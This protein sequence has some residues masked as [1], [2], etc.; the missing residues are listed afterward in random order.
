MSRIN[1]ELL[2]EKSSDVGEI[3]I[4]IET[5][6]IRV[7][8]D[9]EK[10]DVTV[11]LIAVNSTNGE[12]EF[13]A[14]DTS[15]SVLGESDGISDG[16]KLEIGE[17]IL[18]VCEV[19]GVAAALYP[20]SIPVDVKMG[21]LCIEA[22]FTEAITESVNVTVGGVVKGIS[23]DYPPID[24]YLGEKLFFEN[25]VLEDGYDAWVDVYINQE[26]IDTVEIDRGDWSITHKLSWAEHF[27]DSVYGA[28]EIYVWASC[29]EQ[30]LRDGLL[31]D[32]VFNIREEDAVPTAVLKIT[33]G[34]ENEAVEKF[35]YPVKN[36]S[37]ITLDMT[38]SVL[39]Y[40]ASIA[41]RYFVFDGRKINA[42]TYTTD[43]LTEAGTHSCS[44]TI[45]DSR[46]FK[47][48]VSKSFEVLDYAPPTA[49]AS[50]FRSDENGEISKIGKYVLV[51]AKCNDFFSYDGV[52][53]STLSYTVRKKSDDVHELEE[54]ALASSDVAYIMSLA[55]DIDEN[56][57]FKI[58]CRDK[59]GG[60]TVYLYELECG[61]VEL[62]IAKNRFAVG[63]YAVKDELFDC[64]W[65]ARINGDIGFTDS[66]G[67]EV[68]LRN[69]LALSKKSVRFKAVTAET[70]S[71]LEAVLS[72]E[73]D[74]VCIFVVRRTE[75]TE[76]YLVYKLDGENGRIQL[77]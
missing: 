55:L 24:H 4:Y 3:G 9:S 76:V 46:G 64:A 53:E 26:L 21:N 17:K 15:L 12:W 77:N 72:L 6:I 52:N 44:L 75:K 34:S 58:I 22:G 19:K 23:L 29:K 43:I 13:S 70:D 59:F 60:E 36:K 28:G 10:R 73:N 7:D 48:S 5:E 67:S 51:K 40:G 39:R 30:R 16:F 41:E 1:R 42:D 54:L 56:Y 25:V 50:V 37:K 47:S 35:G 71:E 66:D 20:N 2:L 38:E 49:E 57:E 32:A 14:G 74:G 45:T 65:P 27:K 11:S 18:A 61:R 62:N 68:S 8:C 63:K 33:A 69:M 31:R